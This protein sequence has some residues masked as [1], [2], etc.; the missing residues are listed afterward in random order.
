[1]PEHT[2]ASPEA[3][4][5]HG[6][7]L[8]LDK[9]I[10]AWISLWDEDGVMEFPFAPEGWPRRLEGKA[11]VAAY[12]RDYPDHIDLRDIPDLRVHRTEDP[13]TIV[14]EMRAEGR[15][16]ATGAAYDMT[17]IA[18]VTF[19]NGLITGYRDYWNPLAVREPGVDFT[20]S[21]R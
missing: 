6:L 1:M 16:V 19:R 7:R 4:F 10:P 9:D 11:A 15:V 13:G 20:G 18:V 17:Y 8:L 21:T 3:L 12:M 14:V 2:P 5:R